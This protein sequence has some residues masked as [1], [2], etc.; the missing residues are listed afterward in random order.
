MRLLVS[1]DMF[2]IPSEQNNDHKFT[3]NKV[4]YWNEQGLIGKEAF[5]NLHSAEANL[6]VQVLAAYSSYLSYPRVAE[7]T[8]TESHKQC[9]RT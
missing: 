3:I 2:A 9:Y 4:S 6:R 5:T 1:H 8:I 7:L